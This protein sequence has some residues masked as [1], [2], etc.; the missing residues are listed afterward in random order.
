MSL[1]SGISAG[2]GALGS[3][4]GGRQSK[5]N[6]KRTIKAQKEMQQYEWEQ[7]LALYH[8]NNQYNSPEQQMQRL[9]DAGLNPNLV[10]GNGAVGNTSG[11]LPSYDASRPDYSGQKSES[12]EFLQAASVYLDYATKS[13]QID[14]LQA[15]NDMIHEQT[16][17]VAIENL[18]KQFD[19]DLET[20]LR[21]ETVTSRYNK[22][23]QTTEELGLAGEK[24]QLSAIETRIA[25]ETYPIAI[26][27]VQQELENAR[28]R[29]QNLD[30]DF[31]LRVQQTIA[32]RLENEYRELGVTSSDALA[33][34]VI[35]RILKSLFPNFSF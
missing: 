10:Y 29:G 24:R 9:Q 14:N 17:G 18:R 20:E 12:A 15:T 22:S 30:Q 5:K 2:V 25:Q 7:N 35:A 27:M 3:L 16:E 6:V 21:P 32:Q 4:L 1:L 8:Y 23:L 31:L 26:E 34:R 13:A 19:L 33:Y 11:P 28:K